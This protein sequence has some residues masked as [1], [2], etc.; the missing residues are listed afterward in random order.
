MKIAAGC[1]GCLT[2]IFLALTLSWGMIWSSIV[3]ASP[4]LAMSMGAAA[5]YIQYLNGSCCCL[6][7]VLMIVF[8]VVGSMGK[9][10]EEME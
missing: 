9:K 6:S 7:G 8:L 10:N 3:T 5:G 4:D 1:F 2:F